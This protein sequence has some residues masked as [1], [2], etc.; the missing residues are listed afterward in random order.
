MGNNNK[1]FSST[2]VS[3]KDGKVTV[4]H[5][6]GRETTI[7]AG[8]YSSSE[9]GASVTLDLADKRL[10]KMNFGWNP[11][12]RIE[13]PNS[14]EAA[15]IATMGF[16]ITSYEDRGTKSYSAYGTAS[17]R[18][19]LTWCNFRRYGWCAAGGESAEHGYCMAEQTYANGPTLHGA[20]TERDVI[21]DSM[22]A[23]WTGL[24]LGDHLPAFFNTDEVQEMVECLFD[25]AM[26]NVT[27]H[28]RPR[29]R[30]EDKH[31]FSKIKRTTIEK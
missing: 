17:Y 3:M 2:Q 23:S 12:V 9:K 13:I 29:P 28:A 15:R 27:E 26:Q 5:E 6:D 30:A 4:T 11:Q 10:P 20:K 25:D 21:R 7:I 16:E 24:F 8:D 22:V 14:D 31:E 19:G 1:S 18:Q